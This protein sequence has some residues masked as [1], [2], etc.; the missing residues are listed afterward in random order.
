ML[1]WLAVMQS[2]VVV[3]LI[4][5]SIALLITARRFRRAARALSAEVAGRDDSRKESGPNIVCDGTEGHW[6]RFQPPH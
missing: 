5:V 2:L 4:G 1:F 6:I 3:A